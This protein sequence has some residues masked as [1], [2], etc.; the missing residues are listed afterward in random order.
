[1]GGI[2]SLECALEEDNKSQT[3]SS[4]CLLHPSHRQ[5][6]CSTAHRSVWLWSTSARG[7]ETRMRT[8][9]CVG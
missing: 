2:R 9:K 1:M 4:S 8:P 6:V 7:L 3:I 5:A